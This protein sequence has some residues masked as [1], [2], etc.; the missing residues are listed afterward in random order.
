MSNFKFGL[1]D[2]VKDTVTGYKGTIIGRTEWL[3]G[4]KRYC[5][6]AAKL[7]D[8]GKPVESEHVDEG[9]IDLIKA[10]RNRPQAAVTGGPRPNPRRAP[11]PIR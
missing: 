4:C 9:Q 5:I 7:T 2:Q 8:S 1:G 11:D 6:Q 10:A 3:N